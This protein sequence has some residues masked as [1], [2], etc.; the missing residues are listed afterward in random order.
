MPITTTPQTGAIP[1]LTREALVES[2]VKN[3]GL[4]AQDANNAVSHVVSELV[5]AQGGRLAADQNCNACGGGAQR[6]LQQ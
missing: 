4:N 6:Q 3:A 2:L 5:F 1:A